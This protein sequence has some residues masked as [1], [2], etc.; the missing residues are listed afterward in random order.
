MNRREFFRFGAPVAAA[1]LLLGRSS[2]AQTSRALPPPGSDGWISLFNGRN[3]D[4]WYTFLQTSGKDVAQTRGMVTIEEGMLHIMGN[5]ASAQAAESGYIATNQEFENV[6]IRVEYR[7]GTKRF[8]PRLEN[9]RDNG[10]LY[11]LVGADRVWPTC[12]ECQ[13]Q[14]TDTGDYFMLGGTRAAQGGLPG[15]GGAGFITLVAAG[16]RG[17]GAGGRG[18]PVA[19]APATAAPP[20]PPP[21]APAAAPP[22][23]G[24]AGGG[25]GGGRGGT[26]PEP[27]SSRKL[28]DGDFEKLDDWNVVEVIAQGDRS[29][30]IVNGRIVNLVSNIQQPDPQNAGQFIPLT[31]GKIAIEIEYAECWFRRIEIKPLA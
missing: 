30:H 27:T 2:Y 20:P 10:L 23:G 6:R 8:A 29:T 24:R 16:N 15:G 14:E 25:P 1:P 11:S 7:W 19:G 4:G 5:Q 26:P 31:R 12:V 17:A 9:K 13:I 22:A 28:K 18:A 3:L 21:P